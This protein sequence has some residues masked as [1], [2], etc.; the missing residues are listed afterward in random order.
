MN[1]RSVDIVDA[2]A[3][4]RQH[5]VLL[6]LGRRLGGWSIA[7]IAKASSNSRLAKLACAEHGAQRN[8]RRYRP[9]FAQAIA[10]TLTRPHA[11][12]DRV[13]N[14]RGQCGHSRPDAER[15]PLDPRARRSSDLGWRQK[16]APDANARGRR[17]GR[18]SGLA[19]LQAR[20]LGRVHPYCH[21]APRRCRRR[22]RNAPRQ[23]RRQHHLRQSRDRAGG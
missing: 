16:V 18:L 14:E 4:A 3:I 10:C 1:Q 23:D 8:E 20:R 13:G 21:A 2:L 19:P 12:A 22:Q 9:H 17:V 6:R 15:N 5:A 11:G 7:H